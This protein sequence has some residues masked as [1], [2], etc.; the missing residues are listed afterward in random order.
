MAPYICINAGIAL[1]KQGLGT[2]LDWD[3]LRS[4]L[5]I[6]R[7]G[8]LSAAARHLK[9]T[10]TTMGRRLEA[11]HSRSGV[12]LLQ[13]TPAGYMLTFAGERVLA[14][15]ERMEA[16]AF[17]IERA[18]TGEDTKIAGEVRIT[19]VETFGARILIPLLQPLLAA[20]PELRIELITATR[21]LSLSRRE[22]DIALRLAPFEQLEVVVRRIGDM[23]FSAYADASYL[24]RH[25]VPDF[26][27][28]A[29]DH[30]I[31][32]LQEDLALLPE[33]KWL[34]NLT[35]KAR[36]QLRTN[37][38]DA[39]LQAA[40]SGYGIAALPCYLAHGQ[41]SLAELVE[42]VVRLERGIWL[43]IHKDM[44][45]VPRVRLVIDAII[46]GLRHRKRDLVPPAL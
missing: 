33:A 23:A 13:K 21:A 27:D 12:R 31:I 28:G 46:D 41:T 42:P 15:V 2:V 18:I 14:N 17:A 1:T 40:L 5:T 32:A 37:S 11:L 43:G 19:T 35:P 7:L 20:N 38:R 26:T 3:E 8:S 6:A 24:A 4:F 36:V 45:N 44:Q 16:E 29:A 10:Q 34:A 9:V 22:A 25:G 39:Q 30:A